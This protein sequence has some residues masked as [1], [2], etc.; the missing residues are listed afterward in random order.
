MHP[1]P[2]ES[3]KLIQ[4]AALNEIRTYTVIEGLQK[5]TD[6]NCLWHLRMI[7]I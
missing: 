3:Q 5:Q 1:I 4:L 2:A 7:A 6:L